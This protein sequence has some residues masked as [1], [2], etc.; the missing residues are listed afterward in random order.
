MSK[1]LFLLFSVIFIMS[2]GC[3]LENYNR[4]VLKKISFSSGGSLKIECEDGDIGIKS[5]DKDSIKIKTTKKLTLLKF[6]GSEWFSKNENYIDNIFK[7]AT[8][9]L[10]KEGNF[11]KVEVKEPSVIRGGINLDLDILI[12]QNTNIEIHNEDG[13]IDIK[14]IVGDI[15]VKSEDG[16]INLS[17]VDGSFFLE[18]ED[19][20]INLNEVSGDGEAETEDGNMEF[21]DVTGSIAGKT[22]DGRIKC[23]VKEFKIPSEIYIKSG[24]GNIEI[25]I[26]EHPELSIFA[27]SSG[28]G[29]IESDFPLSVSENETKGKIKIKL[30]VEDGNIKIKKK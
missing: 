20:N 5:W 17:V 21:L 26:P 1:K 14:E 9:D 29:N 2:S 18:T 19:G 7:K 15:S 22:D 24:D 16:D 30:F 10:E 13:D 28:D 8:V 3:T 12:P 11:L 25:E 6:F 27:V 23:R 4:D